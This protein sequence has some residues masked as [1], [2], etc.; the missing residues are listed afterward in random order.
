MNSVVNLCVDYSARRC[1]RNTPDANSS[2][3]CCSRAAAGPNEQLLHSRSDLFYAVLD[4]RQT[5]WPVFVV[6]TV[7]ICLFDATVGRCK[8]G[9]DCGKFTHR[10]LESFYF[11]RDLQPAGNASEFIIC[12]RTVSFL[13]VR[14][15]KK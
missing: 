5:D 14:L 13:I 12:S 3:S 15:I 4:D 10:Q 8:I 7:Q 1:A 9:F 2:S 6:E 11:F